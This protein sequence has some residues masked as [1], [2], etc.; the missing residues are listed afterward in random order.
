MDPH[1]LVLALAQRLAADGGRIERAAVTRLE[2]AGNSVQA[3]HAGGSR[4][5]FDYI[6][7][8]AGADAAPLARQLGARVPLTRERGYH[9][10]LRAS[11]LDLGLPVTFAERGFIATP[12]RA[13][14]RLAGTVELGAGAVPDW[15]RADIL[16]RHAGRLFGRSSLTGAGRWYGDRPTLPDYL[17]MIGPAPRAGNAILALGHQ[18]VG[19][20]PG[21]GD[22]RAGRGADRWTADRRF[23]AAVPDR[24]FREDLTSD[25]DRLRQQ[26][27]CR[28]PVALGQ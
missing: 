17:P 3:L 24:S 21:R 13:G 18:H 25:E 6:V 1:S 11:A 8:A 19:L 28:E 16:F 4:R 2:V 10:M 14:I 27:L 20:T 7:L 22:G 26:M 9:L 5:V 23:A 15:R 12:M